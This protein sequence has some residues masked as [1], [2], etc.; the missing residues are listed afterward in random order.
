MYYNLPEK[1]KINKVLNK[2]NFIPKE[3]TTANKK[4]LRENILKVKILG[5]IEGEKIPTC[6]EKNHNVMVIMLLEIKIKNIG[7]AEFINSIIQRKLKVFTI[8]KFID[9]EENII[10]GYGYKRLK[11]INKEEIILEKT[12]VT[13]KYRES[14][15]DEEFSFYGK[16]L[17]FEE[18]RNRN[19]KLDFYLESML[20]A[21]LI[22]N[23]DYIKKWKS[24]IDSN[25]F[26]SR[27]SILEVMDIIIQIINLKNKEKKIKLT[28]EKMKINKNLV[29]LLKEL[30]EFTSG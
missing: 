13:Q 25:I 2:S 30:E 26:Y 16:Y 10:L 29:K 18:I 6:L 7:Q 28:S 21:Y 4:R 9:E 24:V 5:Q 8:I 15:L 27:K 14:I 12:I 20:K 22:F 19:N 3:E 11:E 17:D 1:Y 23:K